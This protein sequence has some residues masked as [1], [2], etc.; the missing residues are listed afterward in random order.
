GTPGISLEPAPP[1]IHVPLFALT[2]PEADDGGREP[3]I[4]EGEAAVLGSTPERRLGTVRAAAVL[5][6]LAAIA[7]AILLRRR[8]TTPAPP[9]PRPAPAAV[10]RAA[11]QTPRSS[12]APA[13][14]ENP[15]ASAS[16]APGPAPAA[17]AAR[18][19]PE[20]PPARSAVARPA[21]ASLPPGGGWEKL[22]RAGRTTF[23]HPGPH[24]YAIQLELACEE[25]TLRKAFA[26]DPGRRS[27]WIAPYA[28]RGRS[29]YRVLWGKYRDLAAAKKAK[30]SLPGIFSEGG[31][32]PAVVSLG[33]A[34]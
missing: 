30:S 14:P 33:R 23:E 6:A 31:N 15:P 32:R 18:R 21:A 11:D 9:P 27:I 13:P 3:E 20:K 5:V 1:E 25:A 7:G 17:T 8:A 16:P 28:F 4:E 24:R 34:R 2:A 26:A 22:A 12:A 10:S 29:C 19:E